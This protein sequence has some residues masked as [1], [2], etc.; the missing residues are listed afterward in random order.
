M[1]TVNKL[2]LEI[3]TKVARLNKL[4]AK[5]VT[6][7]ATRKELPTKIT[8]KMATLVSNSTLVQILTAKG[9]NLFLC[10]HQSARSERRKAPLVISI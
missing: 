3:S 10:C 7:M 2:A 5:I 1:A 8:T 6:K 4:A 9:S